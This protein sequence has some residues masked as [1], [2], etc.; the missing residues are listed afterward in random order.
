MQIALAKF[1]KA[2]RT[3]AYRCD[4]VSINLKEAADKIKYIRNFH[5]TLPTRWRIPLTIDNQF[6][7]GFH[8]G[9]KQSVINSLA[10][11]TG[12]R[13]GKK[14]VVFDEFAHIPGGDDLFYA[15]A[16]AM[17][18]GDLGVDLVSTPM[19]NL[20]L[21]SKIFKNEEDEYGNRPF[22]IFSRHEFIWCDVARFVQEG[23]FNECQHVWHNEMQ[24]DMSRMTELVEAYA[25]DKL[26][27]FYKMFPL[28][29]FLQE[30][31]GVFLDEQTAFF[32]W[33]LIKRC[34]RPAPS[35]IL[36]EEGDI[37]APWYDRPEGNVHQI[38]MGVDFGESAQDTDKTSIQILERT[39][40]GKFMHRYSEV[41]SKT[42]Y[43]DFPAQAQHIAEVARRFQI[44]KISGDHTGLGRGVMP[45]IRRLVPEITIEDV[46]FNLNTKE[47]MVMNLK[48]LME[49]E[50]IWLQQDD[51]QLQGQIRNMRRDIHPNSGRA[52][53]HGE[54]HDDMFWA[55]ALA[56]RGGSY[57]PFVVYKIGSARQVQM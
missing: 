24:K 5:E 8:R 32:P 10:A 36:G 15:A 48:V 54:P 19:G 49:Q 28:Q 57:K 22:S 51:M 44:T 30:F 2:Y 12:I 14:D 39:T 27:F 21:F 16:P 40:S 29:Q 31:C 46:N 11:S 55:L 9:S 7:I 41:L 18:N 42:D 23:K 17:M 33:E 37:L 43:P 3:P 1:F 25:S 6:S 20:N 26:L 52:N 35:G 34:L 56:A 53:Y 45:I 38:F 13:G 50:N 4:I 47:E